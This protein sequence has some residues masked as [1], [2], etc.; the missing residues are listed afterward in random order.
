[1]KKLLPL[2][3]LFAAGCASELTEKN[4]TAAEA[5]AADTQQ[6]TI[7]FKV[8]G[9]PVQSTCWNIARFWFYNM[10]APGLNVTSNMHQEKR[11]VRFNLND[12]KPGVYSL[13]GSPTEGGSYGSFM[14]DYW[15][16]GVVYPISHGQV[17][18][19]EVDT[20]RKIVNGTFYFTTKSREG[21][22][23]EITDGKII[24]GKLNL[25]IS[26]RGK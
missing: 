1:M 12:Y 13:D 4:A 22:S 17:T 15:A 9:E 24:N 2:L 8:D 23:F 7:L 6:N 25:D 26:G 11:T 16:R 21:K 3:C 20:V 19:T 5:P 10:D 18:L 14:P